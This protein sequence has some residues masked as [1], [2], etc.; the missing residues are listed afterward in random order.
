MLQRLSGTK[1]DAQGAANLLAG[2]TGLDL[3]GALNR[4]GYTRSLEYESARDLLTTYGLPRTFLPPVGNWMEVPGTGNRGS[5][6]P[7]LNELRVSPWFVPEYA[8]W[9]RACANV[10]VAG[11]AGSV[12]RVGIY[13]DNGSGYPGALYWE[14]ATIDSTG[15]GTIPS[16]TLAL[17]IP[18]GLWWVGAVCQVAAAQLETMSNFNYA[19]NT[20]DPTAGT[21]SAGYSH[22]SVTGALPATFTSAFF[23]TSNTPVISF[24]RLS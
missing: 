11:G 24:R 18:A 20:Q 6:T 10:N 14:S 22:S 21:A 17:A 19:V 9:D 13:H 2:T 4:L 12:T 8:V 5:A 16:T 1:L 23:S 3:V 7:T 15:T